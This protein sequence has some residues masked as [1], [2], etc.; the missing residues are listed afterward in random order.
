MQENLHI[1]NFCSTFAPDF[2]PKT[3]MGFFVHRQYT[4]KRAMTDMIATLSSHFGDYLT[5]RESHVVIQVLSG[6]SY[7]DVAE[8]LHLVRQRVIHIFNN[9][10][11][12]LRSLDNI[13][14]AKDEQIAILRKEIAD[15]KRDSLP[16]EAKTIMRLLLTPIRDTDLSNRLKNGLSGKASLIYDV[17][18]MRREDVLTIKAIGKKSINELDAWLLAHGLTYEM[19]INDYLK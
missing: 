10:L 19:N 14:K 9:S 7:D 13:L 8:E 2:K 18:C 12:K 4:G 5:P 11:D 17:V 1:S 6:R 16:D 15:L 3:R